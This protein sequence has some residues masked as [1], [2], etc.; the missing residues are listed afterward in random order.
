MERLRQ[1][2]KDRP[3]ESALTEPSENIVPRPTV[4]DEGTAALELVYQAGD[5]IR[6]LESR[7]AETE[8]RTQ[9]IVLQ[10]IDDLELANR[11]VH[12]VEE[13]RDS[14]FA[15]LEEANIQV[16]EIEEALRQAESLLADNEV[17]LSP[18]EL[19]ANTAEALAS[20]RENTLTSV[21]AAIRVRLLDGRP[22]SSRDLAAAA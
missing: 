12:S 22:G 2:V 19:R 4:Q 6:D 15:A 13:Q 21:E 5:L 20:E 10:T 17:Q 11:Y 8:A 18:A 14:A 3:D 16:Q 7:V 9:A 1:H